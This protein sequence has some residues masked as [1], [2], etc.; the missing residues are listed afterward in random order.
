M[1]W[2]NGPIRSEDRSWSGAAGTDGIDGVTGPAGADGGVSVCASQ[3]AMLQWY[4]GSKV[5][6]ATGSGPTGVAFDGTNIWITNA[7]SDTVSKM[8]TGN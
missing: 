3:I 2:C 4:P 1:G 7:G 6:Y 5:D 8:V